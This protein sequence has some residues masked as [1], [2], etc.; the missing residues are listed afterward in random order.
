LVPV[1][2]LWAGSIVDAMFRPDLG[3]IRKAA[4]ALFI[5][6]IPLLGALAYILRRP[7]YVTSGTLMTAR[8]A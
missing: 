5:F 7:R 4:W 6:F 1:V 2:V 8:T 3:K